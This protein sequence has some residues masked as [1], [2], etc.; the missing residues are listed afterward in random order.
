MTFTFGRNLVF[1]VA[2]VFCVLLPP[3]EAMG[4]VVRVG[5]YENAPKIMVDKDG[6]PAGIFID[7][8]EAIAQAEGWELEYVVGNWREGLDRVESGAIDLM[9]DV[10]Y[11]TEREKLYAFHAEPVLS[12]WFQVYTRRGSG[13]SSITEMAG[14]RVLVLDRSVQQA[15]F[16]Q[17]SKG[18]GMELEVVPLPDYQSILIALAEGRGDAA[19]LNRFHGKWHAREYQLADTAIVFNPTSLHFAAPK[20]IDPAMLEA[21]DNRLRAMKQDPNSVYYDTLRRWTADDVTFKLPDWVRWIGVIA[22]AMLLAAL[23][24]NAILKRQVDARTSEL[25]QRNDQLQQMFLDLKQ[26]EQSLRELNLSLEERVRERTSELHV[27]KERAESADRMKSAFLATMSHELR[28]PLNSII[29]FSGILIQRLA[30]PLND[31]QDKQ[32]KML[33][34]SARHLLALIND[35]L[36]ISKIEAG[37]LQLACQTFD[38]RDSVKKA[39]ELVAPLAEK[40]HLQVIVDLPDEPLHLTTDERRFEQILLNL[41]SNGV[42]FTESGSVRI[43]AR[44][45]AGYCVISVTDTGIGMAAEALSQLFQPFRQLDTG[46][47]RKREGTGLGLSICKRLIEM[48]EGNITVK[49]RPGSGSTFT[50]R[51]HRAA[52]DALPPQDAGT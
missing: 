49:S 32:L 31:E 16:T 15:A 27:A 42:K 1:A 37:Q 6:R 18:F 17:M 39:A 22:A 2:A 21:I 14:K 33:Q 46:L 47:S 35:V 48:M 19:I 26:T 41:L 11:T 4:R 9:P 13:L 23:V 38:L 5:V 7:V 8:I 10:A 51:L 30:G 50:I 20:T 25:A 12:D 34:N 24:G 36:D 29:G 40:N 3:V 28:T 44:P 52:A 43:S 45:E